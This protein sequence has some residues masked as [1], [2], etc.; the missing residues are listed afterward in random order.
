MEVRQKIPA[1]AV[2]GLIKG[3]FFS[4][5]F[6]LPWINLVHISTILFIAMG[7]VAVL[8]GKK[9]TEYSW[10]KKQLL[11]FLFAVYYS[12]EVITF[13]THPH[14]ISIHS[15]IE[16]KASLIFIPLLLLMIMEYENIWD[17]GIK[18]FI[19]GNTVAALY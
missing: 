10:Y 3:L 17:I 14:A 4:A 7:C 1:S 16:Q 8:F 18:G 11:F 6:A 13:C 2:T 9:V 19:C 5:M 12:F 15:G